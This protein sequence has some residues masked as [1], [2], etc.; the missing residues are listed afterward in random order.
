[1]GVIGSS[2]EAAELPYLELPDK[3]APWE[4]DSYFNGSRFT[5]TLPLS[6]EASRRLPDALVRELRQRESYRDGNVDAAVQAQQQFH[7]LLNAGPLSKQLEYQRQLNNIVIS[8]HPRDVE[9]HDDP[10]YRHRPLLK[11]LPAYTQL[12]L[13]VP[14]LLVTETEKSLLDLGLVNRSVIN[15]VDIWAHY[16]SGILLRHSTSRWAQDLFEV[17]LDSSDKKQIV[18][19]MSRYQIHDLKRSDNDYLNQ[20]VDDGYGVVKTPLFFRG[21]NLLMGEN[22]HGKKILFIGERELQKGRGDYYT[23]LFI[24]PEDSLVIEMMRQFSGADEVVVISNSEQLFH[25]D[26]AMSF[27]GKGK[28]A[29]LNPIDAT[30]AATEERKVLTEL[31]QRLYKSGFEIFP[32]PTTV[33]RMEKFQSSVNGIVYTDRDDQRI[34][35]FVPEFID[36]QVQ[37][38]GRQQSLNYLIMQAYRRSGVEPMAIEERFHSLSGNLHCAFKVI[39]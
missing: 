32:I 26:M 24:Q 10:L 14:D 23:S 33:A 28:V 7:Q 9:Q 27:I 19:P 38:A 1:M 36:Q 3:D 13:F 6:N 37:H 4:I 12:Q 16:E 17:V 21:G 2:A 34:R 15:S 35:A 11:K 22:R 25:L 5:L 18:I 31:K 8:I 20:L 29:L 39:D 30:G